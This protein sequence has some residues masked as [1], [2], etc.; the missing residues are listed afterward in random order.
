MINNV[1]SRFM[2]LTILA[3]MTL[4]TGCATILSSSN[5]TLQI[6]SEPSG[7]RVIINGNQIGLTPLQYTVPNAKM[8]RPGFISIQKDGYETAGQ[9]I[10]SYFQLIAVLNTAN[11]I[12]WAVD[13][14][15]GNL[16]SL[17]RNNLTVTL[18][19]KNR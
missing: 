12:C 8:N 17:E 1:Y 15:T 16:F 14:F 18:Q 19:P 7:A 9:E 11:I 4:T 2:I 5:K 6:N 3:S 13:F 10:N